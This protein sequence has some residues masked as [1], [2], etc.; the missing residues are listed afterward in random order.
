MKKR[1]ILVVSLGL[2]ACQSETPSADIAPDV[3]SSADT[4][5]DVADRYYTWTLERLPEQAYFAAVE[6]DSHDGLFDNSPQALATAQRTEDAFLAEVEDIDAADLV[7]KPE[8]IAKALLEQQLSSNVARRVCRQELWNISQMGGWHSAYA[9]IA[10][11]QPVDTLEQREQALARWA[12]V[13]AFVDQE[14]AN[15]QTGIEQGYTVPK[16]VAGRVIAQ[17]DGLLA[18]PVDQSPFYSP[19][20]RAN[21]DE[22]STALREIVDTGIQPGLQR[23]RE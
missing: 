22:F 20:L 13:P 8:W 16:T 10:M 15:L 11:L 5:N 3:L 9:Q 21:D 14:I 12:K 7:G 2:A 6:L 4:M 19:A 17:L 23:V 18:L 1:L